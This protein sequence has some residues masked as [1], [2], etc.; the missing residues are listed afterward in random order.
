MA[1]LLGEWLKKYE[2]FAPVKRDNVAIFERIHSASDV[3][4][5]D[6]NTTKP[7]KELLFPQSEAL[8]TYSSADDPASTVAPL[9]DAAPRLLFGVRPCDARSLLLLDRVFDG[10]K[11]KD[12][13]YL[14]RR[15]NTLIVSV[16][17]VKPRATCFCTSVDGGQAIHR[18]ADASRRSGFALV[19]D[20]AY[21]DWSRA[22]NGHRNP[23]PRPTPCS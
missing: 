23:H 21:P 10:E 2:L 17:C 9:G 20:S 5:T 7:P 1:R 6:P 18:Q 16:G 19:I 3:C 8:F 14:N 11:Y 13:Y 15:A 4:L 22:P 12:V